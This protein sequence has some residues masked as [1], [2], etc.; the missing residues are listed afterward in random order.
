VDHFLA[1]TQHGHQQLVQD[2]ED[3]VAVAEVVVKAQVQ[4]VVQLL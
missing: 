3:T 4:A 1:H 2:L